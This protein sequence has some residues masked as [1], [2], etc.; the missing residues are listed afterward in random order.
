[1]PV[2]AANIRFYDARPIRQ[3]SDA[4][5]FFALVPMLQTIRSTAGSW[6]VKILFILLIASFGV[7][8]VGDMFR[9]AGHSSA[10]I[11][12]GRTDIT[13]G[14]ID[15]EFRRQLD[16][17]RPMFG[18]QLT[19]EQA[20]QYG[21]LDQTVN[22]L[23]QRALFDHAAEDAAVTVGQKVVRRRIA[24]EPAFRNAKGE[25]D[26]NIFQS[27]LRNNGLSEGGF[28]EML[29]HDL[30]RELT[31]GVVSNA[32]TAPQTL[33]DALYRFHGEKRAVEVATIP[34]AAMGD[35]GK[36]DD[37][38]IRGYYDDHSVTFT[39]PEYRTLTVARLSAEDLAKKAEIAD[40]DLRQL[41]DERA[42]E[43][44]LPERR[45][46]RMA[47]VND[48]AKA[49]DL[50]T[51]AKRSGLDD[52]A[53][54]AGVEVVA[55]DKIGANDLPG[56]SDAVFSMNAGQISDPIHTD[57]GW[58]VVELTSV[59]PA[60]VKSFDEVKDKLVDAARRE[61]GVEMMYEVSN[62]VE[63]AL[64]AG[65]SLEEVAQANGLAL[66]TLKDID[67][68]GKTAT[69]EAVTTPDDIQTVLKTAF[70]QAPGQPGNLTES[71]EGASFLARVD[72][73]TPPA[74]RPLEEVRDQVIAAWQAEER[75][76]R[77]TTKAEDIANTIKEKGAAG[78]LTA[79][80]T[81]A[82][83]TVA[84]P[85]AFVRDAQ[86]VEGL[87]PALIKQVFTLKPGEAVT[88]T[89][90]GTQ[91]VVRLATITPVDPKA[92][93]AQ[94]DPVKQAVLRGVSGDLSA[95]FAEA[96]QKRYPVTIQRQQ[97]DDMYA[98]ASN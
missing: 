93:D 92:P 80:A 86:Q 25:F 96:L 85:E 23:V 9:K 19:P 62:R 18:G 73:I 47:L 75:E 26:P 51:A 49:N 20:K 41:Y 69:G 11:S 79:L 3:G 31:A 13:L 77:A 90:E 29:R 66:Q 38:A 15:Q 32:A 94:L 45:S 8:G 40:A 59:D 68:T 12:V 60:T 1:M 67:A 21:L 95:A 42:D 43:F 89:G 64:A 72:A 2:A 52:A 97:I 39:A 71:K 57:L 58:Y 84:K 91:V 83:G 46:L 37:A 56:L 78:D 7:W 27:V 4:P 44:Q 6:I 17:M 65:T 22:S 55:M 98:N 54:A 34:N 88:G 10:A 16:R 76:K 74:L 53:K 82:G 70:T 81:A 50:S 61:K 48:E 14:E 30:D 36:P 24:D 63:D 5:S 28:A 87:P 35:V 33:V